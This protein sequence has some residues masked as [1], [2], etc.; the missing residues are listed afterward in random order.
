MKIVIRVVLTK[1]LIKKL[2]NF[3]SLKNNNK[4]KAKLANLEVWGIKNLWIKQGNGVHKLNKSS[5]Y[6]S[7]KDKED[8]FI[9]NQ[10]VLKQTKVKI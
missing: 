2:L 1:I 8:L 4:N 9:F 6:K 3:F 7:S 5:Y 10:L